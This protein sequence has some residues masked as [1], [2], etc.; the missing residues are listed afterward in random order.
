M[1]VHFA[2]TAVAVLALAA[3]TMALAQNNY[4]TPPIRLIVAFPAGGSTDT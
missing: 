3:P 4:P 1:S 2:A